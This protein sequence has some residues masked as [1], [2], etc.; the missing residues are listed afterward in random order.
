[1]VRLVVVHVLDLIDRSVGIA[2]VLSNG[3][4]NVQA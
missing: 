3:I 2:P 1:M 4:G